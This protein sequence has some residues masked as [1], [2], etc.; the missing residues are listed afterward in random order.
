[1]YIIFTIQTGD[2]DLIKRPRYPVA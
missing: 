1:M 2:C